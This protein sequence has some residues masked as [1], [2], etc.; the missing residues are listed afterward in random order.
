MLKSPVLRIIVA[1]VAFLVALVLVQHYWHRAQARKMQA[2][3][4]EALEQA[5]SNFLKK[6]PGTPDPVAQ[7][8]NA[9]EKIAAAM[10]AEQDPAKRARIAA[11]VFWGYYYL[12]TRARRDF[13]QEKGVDITK[14]TRAINGTQLDALN[15]ARAIYAKAGADEFKLYESM[16]AELKTMVAQDQAYVAEQTRQSVAE[17]CQWAAIHADKLAEMMDFAKLQPEVYKALM[18]GG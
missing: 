15:K 17:S 18:A 16:Q 6:R 4:D 7:S 14:F 11:D 9:L 13:C 3:A 12:N 2:R 1:V 5:A 10:E 8:K